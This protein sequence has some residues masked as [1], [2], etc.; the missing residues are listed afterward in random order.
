MM[1]PD[2]LL[3]ITVVFEGLED[4]PIV[5]VRFEPGGHI[6]EP[7]DFI[8]KRGENGFREKTYRVL[9]DGKA[10][11]RVMISNLP[12]GVTCSPTTFV[13]PAG[14]S[15]EFTTTIENSFLDKL[16]S[17]VTERNINVQLQLIG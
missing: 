9:N 4:L 16:D 17:G 11:T 2:L 15:R 6:P 14:E 12:N 1:S 7:L 5:N 10:D 13:V 8:F 3:P